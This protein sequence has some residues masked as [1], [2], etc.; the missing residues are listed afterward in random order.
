MLEKVV[1][2]SFQT[3]YLF[4]QIDKNMYTPESRVLFRIFAMMPDF[5]Y[6]ANRNPLHIEIV[7][8]EGH[9]PV[10]SIVLEPPGMYQGDIR[11]PENARWVY[12]SVG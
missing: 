10:N 1:L 7:N 2:V 6:R 11:I 3:E 12:L 9:F 4:I 8:P 5:S